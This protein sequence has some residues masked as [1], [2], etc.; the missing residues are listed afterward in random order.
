MTPQELV[1]RLDDA[2]R[3]ELDQITRIQGT[4]WPT[5]AMCAVLVLGV[6]AT[7]VLAVRGAIPLWAGLMANTFFGYLAFS[8]AHDAI[9]RA[10]CRNTRV[11]DWIGQLAV[12]MIAPY[13]RL[14]LFRWPR[15]CSIGG[16]I[17]YEVE[18]GVRANRSGPEAMPPAPSFKC[19]QFPT[20][21]LVS[22]PMVSYM[23][24]T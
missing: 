22:T 24:R 13:V 21:S 9:H 14:G 3:R 7:D 8:V 12:M 17:L 4:A 5:V 11:N 1:A 15:S 23:D 18:H 16:G 10:I 6:A 19:V 2:R 20:K